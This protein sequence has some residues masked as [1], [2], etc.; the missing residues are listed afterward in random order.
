MFR[1]VENV[2]PQTYR[3]ESRPS[4]SKPMHISND[5]Y[6]IVD[7]EATCS[8]VGAVP[9]NEMEIIEIGAVVQDSR[10]FEI[11]SE[12]QSFVRPVRNPDLT[13]FCTQL[14][15]ISQAKV[16]DAPIFPRAIESMAQ[17]MS[18]FHD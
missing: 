16:A 11:K 18:S 3:T 10:T 7:V 12:F 13:E 15:G 1:H 2:P 4:N 17:W 14:T 9:R 5:Y 8:D 6:L